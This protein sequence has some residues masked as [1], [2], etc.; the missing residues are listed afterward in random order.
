MSANVARH[1][2]A[3]PD[4]IT[5]EEWQARLDLAACYRLVH[6]FGMD[7]LIYTHI[8]ARVPGPEEHFLINGFGLLYEEITASNLVKV[9]LDGNVVSESEYGINPA[10]YVIHSCI[11]R[12][13]PGVGCVLHTH[14]VA[15]TGVSAQEGGLLPLS[16][17]SM[18]FTGNVAYHDYEGIAL[19]EEEQERL[20]ADLG[21]KNVMILRNHGLLTVGETV[22]EAFL[23][24]HYME[25]ACRMQIAA[26]AG[27]KLVTPPKQ[28]QEYVR[29]AAMGGFGAGVGQREF[30]ALIRR[31]DRQDTSWRE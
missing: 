4:G 30:A 20:V 23:Y 17:T 6:M 19:R 22:A 8:S 16:Q 14:T 9:D 21:E 13:R 28:V 10:G 15:G 27:G 31:L 26:Q 11:H 24:M 18:L 29:Q 2:S 7:D 1:P 25:Q 12:E 3:R 5:A